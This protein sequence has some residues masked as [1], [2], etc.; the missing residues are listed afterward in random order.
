[1]PQYS[2]WPPKSNFEIQRHQCLPLPPLPGQHDQ[3]IL[4]A[5]HPPSPSCD[6]VR[7]VS[8]PTPSRADG[9]DSL[10]R[11]LLPLCHQSPTYPCFL[12][13][14]AALPRQ[15]FLC[16]IIERDSLSIYSGYSSNY[17]DASKSNRQSLLPPA[18][19][20][21]LTHKPA[22]AIERVECQV[23]AGTNQNDPARP[24]PKLGASPSLLDS[25]ANHTFAT[26][27]TTG[28]PRVP[29]LTHSLSVESFVGAS[30]SSCRPST[31]TVLF[32]INSPAIPRKADKS[33]PSVLSPPNIRNNTTSNSSPT[34][35][36]ST[37]NSDID[38]VRTSATTVD[39]RYQPSRPAPATPR[40]NQDRSFFCDDDDDDDNV[41][42]RPMLLR[43][44]MS[45]LDFKV[46]KGSKA[47]GRTSLADRNASASQLPPPL[48]LNNTV[49]QNT[50][51]LAPTPNRNPS[52]SSRAMHQPHSHSHTSA[53]PYKT[54]LLRHN[55]HRAD[56]TAV[57]SPSSPMPPRPRS[58]VKEPPARGQDPGIAESTTNTKVQTNGVGRIQRLIRPPSAIK[59]KA[60]TLQG[61]RAWSLHLDEVDRQ[62]AEIDANEDPNFVRVSASNG[63]FDVFQVRACSPHESNDAD[64]DHQHR[65]PRPSAGTVDSDSPE[66]DS[67]GKWEFLDLS[68]KEQA[69]EIL[70]LQLQMSSMPNRVSLSVL[71]S[72]PSILCNSTIH[73][74]MDNYVRNLA[75][76]LP[77]LPHPENPY[78]SIYVP[79]ALNGV[80][81]ILPRLASSASDP[82]ACDIAVFYA[83]LATSAF[84]L[85]GSDPKHGPD[86]DVIARRFGAKAFA[87]LRKALPGAYQ[88]GESLALC[89]QSTSPPRES[90]ISAMLT[91]VTMD[92][93]EG[94]MS[95]YWVHLGGID[96]VAR[97][98]SSGTED[99][100]TKRQ[101]VTIASFL[102]T[103]ANTTSTDLPPLPWT[104]ELYGTSN[105]RHHDLGPGYGLEFMYGVTPALASYMEQIVALS[106]HI[107][108][109]IVNSLAFP[110]SLISACVDFSNELSGWS[111]ESE[112]L[113]KFFSGIDADLALLLARHHI[114]TFAHGLRL[115]YHT[116]VIL[117]SLSKMQVYVDR[118][119]SHLIEIE[120]V[121]AAAGYDC[122]AS[123]TITWPGFIASCEAEHGPHRQV[124]HQ[125]WTGMLKYRIG[126]IIHL[127]KVVQQAW[128]LKDTEGSAEIP[129]WMPV[130]RRNR[131]RILA[132]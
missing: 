128:K 101:L 36:S 32:G 130:L 74:L 27:P 54:R 8:A 12:S 70:D 5:A 87:S 3:R 20:H 16:P 13:S 46:R 53:K 85:R 61:L 88:N 34:T 126:N 131:Q 58:M 30:L 1:M 19:E 62:I 132:I 107:S 113:S 15:E 100:R 65:L 93:M 38:F 52:A 105:S 33:E 7:R 119:A 94:S 18:P 81:N 4:P 64:I 121:K 124:W 79:R 55:R 114:L 106:R 109:H 123:A 66:R 69:S 125:W 10:A 23:S 111:I 118:V 72:T 9:D 45:I 2:V 89:N 6:S 39:V 108:Y 17:S 71:S 86:L 99:S 22:A 41:Q 83:I 37:F 104:G 96:K 120:N 26:S 95:E 40:L 127:W 117:C 25:Y 24:S 21:P 78:S 50:V 97:Q 60:M 63:P 43:F 28:S 115:Y 102:S 73:R 77:P 75:N 80:S 57:H 91:L 129:A 14:S 59:R 51:A 103:L 92:I 82:I 98:L 116:R 68:I 90:V 11:D 31:D 112:S 48:T 47:D 42:C 56:M 122:N 44:K 49:A 110:P 67:L 35:V 76:V 84:H 29:S